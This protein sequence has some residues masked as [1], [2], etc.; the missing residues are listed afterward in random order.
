MTASA[1]VNLN[2]LR[3]EFLQSE[4]KDLGISLRINCAK[5]PCIRRIRQMRRSFLRFTQDRL[6]LLRMTVLAVFPQPVKPRPSGSPLE[7]F[8][9]GEK[10]ALEQREV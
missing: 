10:S 4:A 6:R 5:N 7:A 2:D 3:I 9:R 1:I 8:L